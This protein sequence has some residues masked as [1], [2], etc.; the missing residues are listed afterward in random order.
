MFEKI[1]FEKEDDKKEFDK[2]KPLKGVDLYL[3]IYN[4]L[5]ENN[6]S[7]TYSEFSS[8][9]RYDKNLRYKLYV[10][11][12]TVEEYLRSQ[13]LLRYDVVNQKKYEQHCF[14]A[15]KQNV[16]ERDSITNSSMLY[17]SFKIF[18]ILA[19]TA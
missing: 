9:I 17:F 5:T 2:Y 7:I 18:K 4:I 10:Y 15:L 6:R 12:A 3:Q 16:V 19:L 14:E 1:K 8:Y 13:F 11:M